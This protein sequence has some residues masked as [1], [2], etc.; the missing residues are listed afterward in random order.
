MALPR[1]ISAD[2]DVQPWAK[3]KISISKN[4]EVLKVE[5]RKHSSAKW[6]ERS[7]AARKDRLKLPFIR[8]VSNQQSVPIMAG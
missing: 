2:D 1:A 6:V 3:L 5:A 8:K 4:S 7:T